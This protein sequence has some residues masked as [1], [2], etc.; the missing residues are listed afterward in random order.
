MD[1]A[2]VMVQLNC[3]EWNGGGDFKVC[4]SIHEYTYLWPWQC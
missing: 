1:S 2:D 4:I 3:R